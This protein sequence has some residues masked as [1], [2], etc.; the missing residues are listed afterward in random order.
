MVYKL[1]EVLNLY[2]TKFHDCSQVKVSSCS[3]APWNY[4]QRVVHS[5]RNLGMGTSQH[6][7]SL[8][9]FFRL[10]A[11]WETVRYLLLGTSAKTSPSL[12]LRRRMR[13]Y[14]RTNNKMPPNT[15]KTDPVMTAVR[16]G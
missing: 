3:K 9:D 1:E 15:A 7:H 10:H 5:W 8:E 2:E 4:R 11:K 12:L 13:K 16:E 6:Y 14:V